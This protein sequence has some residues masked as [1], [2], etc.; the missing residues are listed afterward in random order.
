MSR[1]PPRSI[2]FVALPPCPIDPWIGYF[3]V[4]TDVD[5]SFELVH[6]PSLFGVIGCFVLRAYVPPQ[7][8]PLD[9]LVLTLEEVQA[10]GYSL[11]TGW[12]V[13]VTIVIRDKESLDVEASLQQR[14]AVDP[15][16]WDEIDTVAD[17]NKA[18]M[19][20]DGKSVDPAAR[21]GGT[22]HCSLG[23]TLPSILHGR[24]ADAACRE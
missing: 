13:P 23:P 3:K 22:F 9:S 17:L 20:F 14:G 1:S 15:D 24:P 16:Y 11:D 7:A 6:Q 2:L 5:G 10:L 19:L 21:N 12:T 18:E 4:Q 8:L